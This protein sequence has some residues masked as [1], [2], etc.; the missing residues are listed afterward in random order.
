MSVL[1]FGDWVPS[2]RS[3]PT[4]SR[5]CFP[6]A[7]PHPCSLQRQLLPACLSMDLFLAALELRDAEPRSTPSALPLHWWGEQGEG[8][9]NGRVVFQ[10]FQLQFS[11]MGRVTK[12][13]SAQ[14]Y[15]RHFSTTGFVS[16]GC[17]FSASD[18]V[19]TLQVSSGAEH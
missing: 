9:C 3:T 1:S 13:K 15:V 19:Y 11:T 18:A 16:K 4:D 5:L 12:P 10:P 17:L 6:Q 7:L 14:L 2:M 8:G